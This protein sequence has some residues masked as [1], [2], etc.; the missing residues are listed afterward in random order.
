MKKRRRRKGSFD[1]YKADLDRHLDRMQTD[2]G[3]AKADKKERERKAIEVV[4][5]VYK[6]L[7]SKQFGFSGDEAAEIM[8]EYSFLG[9]LGFTPEEARPLIASY[10]ETAR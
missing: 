8:L 5:K 7:T 4:G 3:F 1:E 6:M 9:K 2:E 10:L